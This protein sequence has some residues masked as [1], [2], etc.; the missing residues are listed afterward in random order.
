[1]VLCLGA[2]LC[3]Q[4]FAPTGMLRTTQSRTTGLTYAAAVA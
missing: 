4:G 2:A 3:S 1:M